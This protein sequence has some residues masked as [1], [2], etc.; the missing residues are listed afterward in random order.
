MSDAR[1]PLF[2]KAELDAVLQPVESARNLPGGLYVES[3]VFALERQAIFSS[4]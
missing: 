2:R 1:V 4:Q 3:E